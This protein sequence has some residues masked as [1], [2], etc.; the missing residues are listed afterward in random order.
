MG[1]FSIRGTFEGKIIGLKK[2]SQPL[3]HSSPVAFKLVL[4]TNKIT[5]VA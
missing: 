5:T 4:S 2:H 1:S 3:N